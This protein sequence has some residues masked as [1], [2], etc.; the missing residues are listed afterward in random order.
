MNYNEKRYVKVEYQK[1]SKVAAGNNV[2]SKG[3]LP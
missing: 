2:Y 1:K 3:A